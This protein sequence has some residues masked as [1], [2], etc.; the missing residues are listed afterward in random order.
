LLR[1]TSGG[2]GAWRGVGIGLVLAALTL[3]LGVVFLRTDRREDG[4]PVAR[5]NLARAKAALEAGDLEGAAHHLEGIPGD[6]DLAPRSLPQAEAAAI[7]SLQRQL[8]VV[9]DLLDQPLEA[10]LDEARQLP[11]A[12]W[13]RRFQ[14]LYQG[15]SIILEGW[16]QRDAAAGTPQGVL[17]YTLETRIER[18]GL[19]FAAEEVLGVLRFDEEGRSVV[20]GLRLQSCTLEVT[21]EMP[22]GIWMV[23][24]VP[25]STVELTEP[26]LLRRFQV[27]G[28]LPTES[29]QLPEPWFAAPQRLPAGMLAEEVSNLLGKPSCIVRQYARSHHYEQWTYD[30]RD[31]LRLHFQRSGPDGLFLRLPARLP[32]MQKN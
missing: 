30:G 14:D 19:A 11:D 8:A 1:E 25:G 31:K 26:S 17:D 6:P 9:T 27:L 32:K 20:L 7:L 3:I 15:R 12:E 10:L 22:A 16:L 29:S 28:S 5:A 24:W 21:P 18:G 2:F 23:R 13:Q 4:T